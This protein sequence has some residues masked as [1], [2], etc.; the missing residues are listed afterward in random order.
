MRPLCRALGLSRGLITRRPPGPTDH[1]PKA[2]DS[3][4]IESELLGRAL[5]SG[6]STPSRWLSKDR[7]TGALAAWGPVWGTALE[8]QAL[9]HLGSSGVPDPTDHGA[10]TPAICPSLW[11]DCCPSGPGRPGARGP[12]QAHSLPHASV[13]KRGTRPPS[14]AALSRRQT[15]STHRPA[16]RRPRPGRPPPRRPQL[17]PV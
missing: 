13:G 6:F 17:L 7:G 8:R 4:A 12:H 3:Q 9:P 2:T 11:K 14:R 1:L 16:Q 15:P 10:P 5:G